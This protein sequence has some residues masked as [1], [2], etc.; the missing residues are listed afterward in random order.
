MGQNIERLK[1]VKN[2]KIPCDM[3]RFWLNKSSQT[4][5]LIK[6]KEE[7]CEN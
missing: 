7:I 2:D 6:K 4:P 3:Y 1:M 5:F